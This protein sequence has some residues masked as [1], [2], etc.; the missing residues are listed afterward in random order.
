[1]T[2]FQERPPTPSTTRDLLAEIARATDLRE[3]REGVALVMRT[4]FREG[5]LPLRDLARVV[6]MPLPVVGAV[7]RELEARDLLERGQGVALSPSGQRFCRE[8]LGLSA[9][10][11]PRCTGCA[12][13]G[14]VLEP[15]LHE[16]VAAMTAHIA[17]GPP[18]DVTLDQAPCTPETSVLRA[19]A[20]HEAGAIEGREILILGDDD[21]LSVALSL[22][23]KAIGAVPRR[24]TVL[25][26]DPAR[27]LQLQEAAETH[28]Y[29]VEILAH[30][31]RD[32]LPETLRRRF[33]VFQ[34]DPPY[35]VDGMSLFVSRGL[36]GLR[37][38]PGLPGFLSFGDLSPDDMLDVQER[39]TLMGCVATRIR[40]S[41]NTYAGA[42][43]LGSVGQLIELRTTRRSRPFAERTARFAAPIYTG[44]VRP[45][46]RR[47]RCKSCATIVAVGS[48]E[49]FATVEALKETGC[50][51]CGGTTFQR[52]HAKTP[53]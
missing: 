28:D 39:L 53:Y 8:E 46:E 22:L 36:E 11:D 6:R 33:D 41:F 44:E 7:R 23:G 21:S 40:P 15:A 31:L 49:T 27:T 3:G 52:Q 5:P 30:D 50:P 26:L 45:R 2:D 13:R 4:A 25:E 32:P 14:I 42:S 34:T 29:P 20:M 35:T 38:E 19:L 43:I 12:G 18:V 17:A 10:H 48:G 24:L 47:Y 9:R 37:A 1:M 16:V 51:T